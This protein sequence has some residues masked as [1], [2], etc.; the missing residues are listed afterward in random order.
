MLHVYHVLKLVTVILFIEVA[1]E[2]P[3]ISESA[4]ERDQDVSAGT[5]DL[6]SFARPQP[7]FSH[8]ISNA[9]RIRLQGIRVQGKERC[10]QWPALRSV[11]AKLG[12]KNPTPRLT[13]VKWSGCD[14]K[15]IRLS[16]HKAI[17][18]TLDHEI[19]KL[20]ALCELNLGDTEVAGDVR[21]LKGLS[22]LQKL[23][24]YNTN[25][26]GDLASLQNLTQLELLSL[27]KTNCAGELAS[28]QSLTQLWLLNLGNTHIAGDLASLQRLTQLWSLHLPNTHVSGDLASLQGLTKLGQLDLHNTN[29]AGDLASLQR[30]TKL[31]EL[32]LHD[33]NVAGDLA[34]LQGL[35]LLQSL[36]LYNTK[37]AGDL[38]SMQRLTQLQGLYLDNTDVVGDLV[39]LQGLTQVNN[40]DLRNTS[41]AG[42]LTALLPWNHVTD[43]NLEQTQ[44]TGRLGSEWRGRWSKLRSLKLSGSQVEFLP[45]PGELV[46][47]QSSVWTPLHA[48]FSARA[49]LPQLNL[50]QLN[51]CPLN[52]DV[53]ELLQPLCGS[54]ALAT[55]EAAGCRLS[56]TLTNLRPEDVVVDGVLFSKWRPLLGKS[57][58]VLNLATNNITEIKGIPASL[59][60]L[61][62]AENSALNFADGVLK[63]ALATGTFLDLQNV[64]LSNTTEAAELLR[65]GFIVKTEQV[66]SMSTEGG[67]R[68]HSILSTSLQVS[69]EK[70]LPQELCRC[71]AGFE[72]TG[73]HCRKCGPN[74]FSEGNGSKCTPCPEGTIA[75][76]GEATCKCTSGGKFSPDQSPA[77][78]CHA[79]HGLTNLRGAGNETETCAP[80]HDTHLRCPVSGMLLTSAPPEIGFARLR[81]N[82]TAA[83]RCLPPWDT[84]CNSTDSNGSTHFGCA[85][86]YGGVLCSD[87]EARHY[88]TKG[89][90]E[91]CPT[92]DFT[93]QI[94]SMAAV[95]GGIGLLAVMVLTYVWSRFWGAN[96]TAEMPSE[97]A[98][99]SA[100]GAFK[101][102][103]KQ[104]APMLLQTC[105]LWAVLAALK[106]KGGHGSSDSWEIPFIEA[107]QLSVDSL[108]GAVNLQCALNDGA[109]VRLASALAAPVAPIAVLLCCLAMEI[110]CHGFGVASA[111]KALTLFYVGGASAASKLLRCQEVDGEK[112]SLPPEFA[113]RKS[114]PHLL[115][116]DSSMTYLDAIGY[117]SIVFYG[118]VVPLCLAYLYA[119]QHLA[120]LPGKA[121]APIAVEDGDQWDIQLSD[122]QRQKSF[123]RQENLP[124]NGEV[125]RIKRLL[126]A[127]AAH[128]A[129]KMHGRAH[130]TLKDGV[131]VATPSSGDTCGTSSERVPVDSRG[132]EADWPLANISSFVEAMGNKSRDLSEALMD[133]CL[134]EEAEASERALAGAKQILF[135]YSRC[136]SFYLEIIQKL[137]A[138]GLVS[139]VNSDDGL[140][141]CMA[142]TLLMAAATGMAQ[143]YFHPQANSV[144]CCSFACLALA[145]VGFSYE[146]TWLS[147]GSLAVPFLLSAGLALRPDSTESLAVRI[148]RQMGKEI[149]KLQDG[150]PLEVLV[151]TVSF[152]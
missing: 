100:V 113:F 121:T 35:T 36:S 59:Q 42:D 52:G 46:Q 136:Q 10:P 41:V 137:V 91:P 14:V 84:R 147:R 142:F 138:V 30:L 55:I 149:P 130:V 54:P 66:S 92:G 120:L 12:I 105:Q 34:S 40:L 2:R 26:G 143:P 129:V 109:A 122:L 44:V 9:I 64:A 152:V 135:K 101:D 39:S 60:V 90:C 21:H 25:V 95:A 134:L 104:V 107:S 83:L 19:G 93:Q 96:S 94:W 57:L 4:L 126:A 65:E 6:R 103:M 28:L 20:K 43:I 133:R 125:A 38:S 48:Q 45:W 61:I 11:L 99:F 85:S 132:S 141:L 114:V 123:E 97:A 81:N 76:E 145:A 69:P 151:E 116:H 88:L 24:L 68:C 79:E 102:Q 33:N 56:G 13:R 47:L 118:V 139:V 111:L 110:C 80:C 146:F 89:I 112:G 18:G 70:F 23:Y 127:S 115:C 128:I 108:E 3:R 124:V 131:V 62:L 86:G 17:N 67:Y 106:S 119:R 144:Q 37:V 82:D 77:C 74:T 58:K 8:G 75:G 5:N 32:F 29:V 140:Q 78:Q 63:E 7:P 150:K 1:G 73:A 49:I 53:S 98:P 72:G 50:L 27:L 148:W 71:S 15:A 87:C 22:K 31:L 117:S 51:G 16:G